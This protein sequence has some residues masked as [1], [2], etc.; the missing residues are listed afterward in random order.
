[1]D[2]LTERFHMRFQAIK[3]LPPTTEELT[4]FLSHRWPISR[5]ATTPTRSP[6]R[7]CFPSHLRV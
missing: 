6:Y 5:Q 3:L 4:S 2:L 1:M 7:L